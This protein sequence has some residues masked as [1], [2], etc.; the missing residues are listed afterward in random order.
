MN[1]PPLT[2]ET[3]QFWRKFASTPE[4]QIGLHYLRAVNAPAINSASVP[5]MIESALKWQG[6]MEALHA[7]EYVLTE[8]KSVPQSLEEPPLNG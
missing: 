2:K 7:I 3:V 5:E 6:Y 8:I 4:F 1:N